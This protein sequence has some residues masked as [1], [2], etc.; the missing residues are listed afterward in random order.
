[1]RCCSRCSM[2]WRSKLRSGDPSGTSRLFFCTINGEYT[3]RPVSLGDRERRQGL[4]VIEIIDRAIETGC[5]LPAPREGACRW[6]DFSPG[7]RSLGGDPRAPKGPRRSSRTWRRC[8]RCRKVPA[9]T[10]RRASA[11][12]G[13]VGSPR[14]RRGGAGRSPVYVYGPGG[15]ACDAVRSRRARRGAR[16]PARG[17]WGPREVA[18]GVR[19]E[20]PSTVWTWRRCVRCRKVPARTA[21]RASAGAGL[22]GSPRGRRGG[23]GRSPVYVW[24]WRSLRAMP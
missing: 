10:A 16:R 20:A 23:A 18:A 13:L 3:T 14:G 17:S 9:R 8:V 6:C 19:G 4:E 22:V 21:R 5:L 15:A 2:V 24:T 11:G 1:M 7:L 12:A